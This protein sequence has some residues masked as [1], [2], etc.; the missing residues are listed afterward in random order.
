MKREN[1]QMGCDSPSVVNPNVRARKSAK[2]S[3]PQ[4]QAVQVGTC[5]RLAYGGKVQPLPSVAALLNRAGV[6]P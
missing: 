5:W 6:R 2:A 3:P 4:W 1:K